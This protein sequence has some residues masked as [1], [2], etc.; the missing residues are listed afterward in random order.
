MVYTGKPSRGCQTCKSRRIKCDEIRP[1]CTQC[2]K[3]GRTCPGYPDEFDLIFRDEN[4]ALE[5]RAR[6][7][8]GSK[9]ASRGSSRPSPSSGSEPSP[10]AGLVLLSDSPL[11]QNSP[12]ADQSRLVLPSDHSLFQAY[13]WYLGNAVPPPLAPSAETQATAFF[14]RN[15]VLLPQQAES[16]RGFLELLVPLYNQS[17]P[18]SAL[19]LATHAVSLSTLGNY[20]GR[21][22][23]LRDASVAYGQALK[24][25]KQALE[26]PVESKAD[27]TVLAIL[28]FSLY[29]AIV[30]T[31]ETVTAWAS[32]VDGA[33]ALTKLRGAEQFKN[34]QSYQV[35]RAVRTM[36]IT[37]CVQRSKPVEEFPTANG[38]LGDENSQ[39]NAAN[40]LT[41]ISID[42]PAIRARARTLLSHERSAATEAEALALIEYAQMVDA[43]LENW[44]RTLPDYWN[45]RT[46]G[47]VYDMPEDLNS[48]EQWPGPQHAYD[49]VFIANIINDYRVS[50]I[51]CQSVILGCASWLAPDGHDSRTDANCINAHFVI[52][53]MADEIAASVPFHVS[54]DM[55]PMA[56]KLGQDVS[57]AEALGGYFLVW[58]LFVA[59]NA[60]SVPLNQRDW[61]RGRLYHIGR[62]FGLSNAQILVLARRHVLTCGPMFP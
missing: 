27:E 12:C 49:D 55:Q 56:K 24:K 34:P 57:A 8:S 58:P 26:D 32:H 22:Q 62:E 38:W 20:P 16:M 9:S 33:V 42:L 23:L 5:R 11:S 14:F 18:F 37:S 31:N 39:E 25:V 46:A 2:R 29:E 41:L 48:A 51:F 6:K 35:F 30:S 4:A 13:L 7:A 17:M 52:Q 43:N 50:R 45:Y 40:R 60:D 54:Y 19:H 21:H 61:F 3:S 15:F 47:M 53:E 10:E 28:M 44:A 1:T 59:A 36:M